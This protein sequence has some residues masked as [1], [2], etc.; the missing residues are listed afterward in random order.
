[1]R[2]LFEAEYGLYADADE[3]GSEDVVR[4]SQ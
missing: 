2:T 1:M 3:D 4:V